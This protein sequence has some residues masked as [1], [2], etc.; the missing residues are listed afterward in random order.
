IFPPILIAGAQ[1]LSQT[2]RAGKF[3]RYSVVMDS[4]NKYRRPA[5]LLVLPL[6][7]APCVAAGKADLSAAQVILL[8]VSA[9]ENHSCYYQ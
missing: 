5:A 7:L 2:D 4:I 1:T 9:G 3:K 8:S 6:F